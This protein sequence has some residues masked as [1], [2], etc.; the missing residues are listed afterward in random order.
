MG[1]FMGAARSRNAAC[2]GVR[3]FHFCTQRG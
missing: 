2:N 3:H 1:E